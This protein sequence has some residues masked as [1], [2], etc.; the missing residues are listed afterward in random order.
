MFLCAG[1]D[2]QGS[3]GL[4]QV[5]MS[6]HIGRIFQQA[7]FQRGP[8]LCI[9]F[10]L[11]QAFPPGKVL[12]ATPGGM[13]ATLEALEATVGPGRLGLVHAN[14]SLGSLLWCGTGP[15]ADSKEQ[16]A[17]RDI[18]PMALQHFGEASP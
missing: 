7:G 1:P 12:L 11:Q 17:L 4:G 13:A 10:V 5:E 6:R 14:D 15:A 18:T 3:T 8:R 2:F 9:V 16:W